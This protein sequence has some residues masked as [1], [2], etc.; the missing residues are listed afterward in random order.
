M[1]RDKYGYTF[2]ILVENLSNEELGRILKTFPAF[3]ADKN[4]TPIPNPKCREHNPETQKITDLAETRTCPIH[5]EKMYRRQKNG[6]V[7]FSHKVVR[8]DGSTYWCRG[9]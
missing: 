6:E 1:V 3:L 9:E 2:E 8:P 5:S 4:L 7:W